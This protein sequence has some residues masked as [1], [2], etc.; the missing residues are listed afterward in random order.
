MPLA[1]PSPTAASALAPFRRGCGKLNRSVYPV[2]LT[3]TLP[4][5]RE[6]LLNSFRMEKEHCQA[7]LARR[8]WLALNDRDQAG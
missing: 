7:F 3:P 2:A 5:G 6:N 1:S 8:F 4:E